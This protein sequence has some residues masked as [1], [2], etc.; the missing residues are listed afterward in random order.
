MKSIVFALNGD[1]R[2][3]CLEQISTLTLYQV[4]KYMMRDTAVFTYI[5]SSL[6]MHGNNYSNMQKYTMIQRIWFNE[7]Y[8]IIVHKSHVVIKGCSNPVWSS[9]GPLTRCTKLQVAHAPGMLGTFSPPWWVS[10]PNMHH[11]M[12]MTHMPW[13][14]PGSLTS[15]FLWSRWQGIPGACA[16]RNF[17]YLVWGSWQ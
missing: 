16:S 6:L 1:W 8:F 2:Y 9:H 14:M 4:T 3:I 11:G 13:Y 10:N 7:I 5:L 12:C 15:V 17:L